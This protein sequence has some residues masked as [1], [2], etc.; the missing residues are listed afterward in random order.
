M[1]SERKT[2]YRIFISYSSEDKDQ[3]DILTRILKKNNLCPI[4]DSEFRFGHGFH[5]QIKKFIA[6][7]YVFMPLVS[8]S[9]NEKGWVHEEIG[10]AMA[11]NIPVLPIVIEE[12]ALPTDMIQELQAIKSNLKT[13]NKDELSKIINELSNI[14]SWE[15]INDLLKS[16]FN[17]L[18]RPVYECAYYHLERTV[19]LVEYSKNIS[20]LF[21]NQPKL[22]RQSGGLSSFH[23]PNTSPD[24]E[25]FKLR[26]FGG[27]ERVDTLNYWLR[28]ERI[29]FEEFAI[30][31][32]FKIIIDL[33]LKFED[34][35]EN[36]FTIRKSRLT[37][38]YKF[39][40]AL[41]LAPREK[42]GK[43]EVI[44]DQNLDKRRN[45]IIVGDLFMAESLAG[46]Q[47]Q[48]LR[49]TMFTRHAP[50][51]NKQ[52]KV[53]DSRFEELKEKQSG[54]TSVE[55]AKTEI[56]KRLAEIEIEMKKIEEEKNKSDKIN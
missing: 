10:Y 15:T 30:E 3:K 42:G 39:F 19:M 31:S 41:P 18:K 28:E 52:I 23:I 56:L 24:G 8:K 6:H 50:S 40:E 51:I 4:S 11:H 46:Y 48:G 49:Q 47:G 27:N 29:N 5:D 43:F 36:A 32:G 13:D 9:S 53:F 45:V 33:D 22:F 26:Y 55:H 12:L 14:L 38:L 2:K 37:T 35:K 17:E 21:R 54:E 16:S 34:S 44:I 1:S 20:N 25:E 7:A